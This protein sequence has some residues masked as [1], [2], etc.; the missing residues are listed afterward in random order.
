[1]SHSRLEWLIN[2]GSIVQYLSVQLYAVK[3]HYHES[4]R[5]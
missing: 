4:F 5:N 2:S 1:M 3:P